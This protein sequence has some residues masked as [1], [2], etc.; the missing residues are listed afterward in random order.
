MEGGAERSPRD[1]QQQWWLPGSSAGSLT[2]A[3]TCGPAQCARDSKRRRTCW[4]RPRQ[5]NRR[6]TQLLPLAFL[7]TSRQGPLP[8]AKASRKPAELRARE[9]PSKTEQVGSK[10]RGSEPDLD[11]KAL[12]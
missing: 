7:L 10:I 2:T 11:I 6:R 9:L 3:G 12:P 1:E 8:C 5:G 4:T